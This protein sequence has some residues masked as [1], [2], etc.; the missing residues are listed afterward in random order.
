MTLSDQEQLKEHLQSAKSSDIEDL[1]AA[2]LSCLLD[3]PIAV[4]ASGFQHGADAGPAGE[5]GRRFRLECKAYTVCSTLSER[6]LLGEIDQALA[7]DD[8]L[9][10][11]LL[12][13]TCT[14]SE[15]IRQSLHQHGERLGL[16]ILTIDWLD[17]DVSPLSALCAVN[18][19]M[20][21]RLLSKEA[22]DAAQR[23]K[24]ASATAIERLRRSLQSWCL[25]FAAIRRRSHERLLEI[26]NSLESRRRRSDTTPLAGPRRKG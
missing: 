3:L 1:V 2:L 18:P 17:H 13:A 4:A 26:W 23:L 10:A 14:V 9:E 7:R 8:A 15:Q 24:F 12:V 11:W 21:Q 20:V 5:H 6:E 25:G 22:A 19:D 16:P